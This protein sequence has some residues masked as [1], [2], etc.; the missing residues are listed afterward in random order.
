M[1]IIFPLK[2][3]RLDYYV[4][5]L[6]FIMYIIMEHKKNVHIVSSGGLTLNVNV[7]LKYHIKTHTHGNYNTKVLTTFAS[8]F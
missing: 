1:Y 5:K 3:L 6:H 8:F 2:K 4:F 7:C